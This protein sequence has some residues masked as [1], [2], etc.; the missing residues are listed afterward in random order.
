MAEQFQQTG[1]QRASRIPL[2]YFKQSDRIQRVKLWLTVLAVLGALG[3]WVGSRV[4]SDQGDLLYSRGPVAAVHST[5]N[6]ECAACHVSFHPMGS[7]IG[8]S[9]WLGHAGNERCET[10]HAG[11][12]HSQ[13]QIAGEVGACADCHRD[14]RGAD[15]SLVRLPDSDC[16][17]CHANLKDHV[18]PGPAARYL[19]VT[20]F[21]LQGHPQFAALRESN[22]QQSRLKFNHHVHMSAGMA[23]GGQGPFTLAQVPA[24][25]RAR[26]RQKGQ[27]PAD[28]AR[29]KVQ[30]DCA[31]CHVLDSGD[32]RLERAPLAGLPAD[33]LLPPRAA[34]AYM[35]PITYDNQCRAC[36]PLTVEKPA[37]NLPPLTVPHRQQPEAIYRF[38][39]NAYVGR[40]LANDP[41]LLEAP[42]VPPR[43][44]PGKPPAPAKPSP[45]QEK[46]RAAIGEQI[47]KAET[48]L[49]AHKQTCGECHDYE[50]AGKVLL[51]SS[52]ALLDSLKPNGP[53][54]FRI[55]QQS[56][57][58]IW[59][60]HARFDHSSHR[61]L[62][63]SAC[64][65][66]AYPGNTTGAETLVPGIAN[67][68]QCHAPQR[69]EGGKLVGGARFDCTE[70]HRYHHG[71]APLE[72]LG[73]GARGPGEKLTVQQFLSG[74]NPG[75]GGK[76]RRP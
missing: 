70:C 62:E 33:A 18:A 72:G 29:N 22:K 46:A 20:R 19:P 65:A 67:C 5:W 50:M 17:R 44:L 4:R 71:D 8:M 16:T 21:D 51:P 1:K 43:T 36:H 25:E 52:P 27:D 7:N 24:A 41:G 15:A 14:H 60:S 9:K 58:P 47:V 53:P 11:P 23:D 35:L 10:C 68:V 76:P 28:D 38:L 37:G 30:L 31:S 13:R 69:H 59:F 75:A 74:S 45:E 63:C 6:A 54:G 56:T 64:H 32:F 66:G 2:D 48:I 42:F 40:Y 55:Q 39:E 3:W 57:T 34:G 61:A 49:Y 73:A 12:P 26:Y